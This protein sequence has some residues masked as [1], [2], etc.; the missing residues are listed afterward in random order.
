M[1]DYITERTQ[2]RE[3]HLKLAREGFDRGE[4]V[5]GGAFAEP[6][7]GVAIV[8]ERPIASLCR[9]FREERPLCEERPCHFL[10]RAKVDDC[11]R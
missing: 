10:A 3:A 7:D 4:L 9:G 11:H 5:L 6:V 2:F 1:N 8:F